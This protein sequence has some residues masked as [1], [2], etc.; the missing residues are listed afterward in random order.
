MMLPYFLHP[1]CDEAFES[2]M[3]GTLGQPEF[4]RAFCCEFAA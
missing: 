4:R 2:R 3:Q 1:E